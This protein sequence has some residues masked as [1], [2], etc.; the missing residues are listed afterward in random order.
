ML[1]IRDSHVEAFKRASQMQFIQELRPRL[2]EHF[3]ERLADLDDRALN[4]Q[5][6][7]TM[8]R[9]GEYDL[10]SRR[11][12]GQFIVLAVLCGWAFDEDPAHPWMKDML[13][14]TS[15]RSPSQRLDMLIAAYMSR[16]EALR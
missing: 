14:D 5:M 6:L 10:T 16:Q 4:E 15:I 13:V 11:D 2:R 7:R 9:A 12:C 8:E 1:T 3:G